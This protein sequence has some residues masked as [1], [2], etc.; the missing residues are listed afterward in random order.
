MDV[1]LS[2]AKELCGWAAR[3]IS[4]CAPPAHTDPSLTLG[5]TSRRNR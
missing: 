3:S 1:I 4:F 2:V 5:M